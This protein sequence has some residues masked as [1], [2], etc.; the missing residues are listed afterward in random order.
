M[1]KICEGCQ[2]DFST[3]RKTIRF[4]SVACSNK[5]VKK[6]H[7]RKCR[8]CEL[9]GKEFV[10]RRKRKMC[11]VECIKKYRNSTTHFRKLSEEKV[12]QII[13]WK[14]IGWTLKEIGIELGINS[15]YAGSIAFGKCLPKIKREKCSSRTDILKNLPEITNFQSEIL[16]GSLLGDGCIEIGKRF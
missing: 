8:I 7:N 2:I 16:E 14:N 11:S 1:I 12:R 13:E 6:Q 3:N 9:C 4:C 10:S 15:H 5:H